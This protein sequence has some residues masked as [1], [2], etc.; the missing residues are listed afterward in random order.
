MNVRGIVYLMCLMALNITVSML[1]TAWS[2][3]LVMRLKIRKIDAT[4]K[5]TWVIFQL[6]FI[7]Y[8]IDAILLINIFISDDHETNTRY[9][10]GDHLLFWIYE[11]VLVLC[12]YQ[13]YYDA[14]KV[15][16]FL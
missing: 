3:F 1:F 11:Q 14:C 16:A 12:Y 7:F 6:K 5:I 10:R 13:F 9:F 4:A 2:V 8:F 15:A